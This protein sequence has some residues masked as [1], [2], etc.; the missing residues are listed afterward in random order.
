MEVGN[1]HVGSQLYVHGNL[2][3]GVPGLPAVC[4]GGGAGTPPINGSAYIEGPALVG[5]PLSFPIPRGPEATL[6]VARSVNPSFPSAP[7]ILKISSRG[8]P[9]TPID[10][11]LG[12]PTG[13]V[14]VSVNSLIF[15]I[16]NDTSVSIT[17]PSFSLYANEIHV[18]TVAQ[19]G[20]KAETGAK[21][22]TGARAESS[23]ACQNASQV[24]NGLLTVQGSIVCAGDVANS[25]TTLGATNAIA[26]QALA[27]A[28]KGFDIP[29]PT[30][31]DHRLRYICLEGPEVGAYIRGTLK[32]SDTIELPEYWTKLCKPETITV[33]LTPIGSWQ[34]LFVE[35]IEWGCRIKVK[36]Q[37]GA[38]IHCNY[39]VFAE[40][41]T[42]D[43]LQVEYKGLTPHDYPGDNSEYAL[44][45]WDYAT[46]KGEPKPP[47]L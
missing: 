38:S 41:V 13:H 1:L 34:E 2:P 31:Q 7:S 28:G 8:F 37:S 45:G 44:G 15:N 42:N 14:G 20:A 26:N 4:L 3:G 46:H 47:T 22:D 43:Q 36:N 30:K 11:M 10:V 27:L 35:K 18:G 9:P 25:F 17:S 16:I 12:D 29:H 6:M 19:T 32:D 21:A 33:N 40:R 39:V 23:L 5:S 24:V